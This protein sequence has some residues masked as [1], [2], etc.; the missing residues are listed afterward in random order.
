MTDVIEIT[1]SLLGIPKDTLLGPSRK[2]AYIRGRQ[3]CAVVLRERGATLEAIGQALN[4]DNSTVVNILKA[5]KRQMELSPYFSK[6][7]EEVRENA[8]IRDT[9]RARREM[10][11]SARV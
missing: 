8:I 9:Q 1:A 11:Y 5:G 3:V 4:R 7:V 10:L 2:Q 6:R